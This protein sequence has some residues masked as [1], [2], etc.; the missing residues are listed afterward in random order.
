MNIQ[1]LTKRAIAQLNPPTAYRLA[2]TLGV[3]PASVYQWLTGATVPRGQRVIKLLEI[4][5]K[6]PND[7]NTHYTQ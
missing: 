6:P 4:A 2:K 3:T 1:E 7:G 5:E